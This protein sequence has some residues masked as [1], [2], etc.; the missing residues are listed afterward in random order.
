MARRLAVTS[1]VLVVTGLVMVLWYVVWGVHGC[2]QSGG[3]PTCDRM[4]RD[5]VINGLGLALLAAGIVTATLAATVRR[6]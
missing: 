5:H 2:D 3:N 1:S 6:S 4:D